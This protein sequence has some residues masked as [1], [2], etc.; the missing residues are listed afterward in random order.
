VR[1]C[2]LSV[3]VLELR[4]FWQ[5]FQRIHRRACNLEARAHVAGLRS[6]ALAYNKLASG[7]PHM[8]FPNFSS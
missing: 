4:G 2:A 7:K 5:P 8:F 6:K 1:V 3:S